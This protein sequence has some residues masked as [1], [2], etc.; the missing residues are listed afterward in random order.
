MPLTTNFSSEI[1]K[2][3]YLERD[4]T[5]DYLGGLYT[6]VTPSLD[7]FPKPDEHLIDNYRTIR[8]LILVVF[9]CMF[10]LTGVIANS[11]SLLV[12]F[13]KVFILNAFAIGQRF[14]AMLDL[15]SM[16]AVVLQ[17]LV[18]GVTGRNIS[19][20]SISYCRWV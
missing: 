10:F 17:Y 5:D 13:Q 6:D 19:N 20:W 1:Y 9:M 14:L 15:V 11:Y 12:L 4:N 16:F 2:H 7:G 8:K 3:P 18:E